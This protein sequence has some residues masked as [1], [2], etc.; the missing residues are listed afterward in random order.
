MGGQTEGVAEPLRAA[1]RRLE[2]CEPI[3]SGVRFVR[4]S[5][6]LET[7]HLDFC[8]SIFIGSLVMV[9]VLDQ[10]DD[11]Q[12]GKH[13]SKLGLRAVPEWRRDDTCQGRR[14]NGRDGK[15]EAT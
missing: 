14:V 1:S 2:R 4:T 15:H 9:V 10:V 8:R 5:N 3:P 6:R 13:S 11:V 7:E 12:D